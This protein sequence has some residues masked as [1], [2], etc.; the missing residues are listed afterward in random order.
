MGSR[1]GGQRPGA[2]EVTIHSATRILYFATDPVLWNW[3]SLNCEQLRW[4]FSGEWGDSGHML[5]A[6][7]SPQWPI[8]INRTSTTCPPPPPLP[9]SAIEMHLQVQW[10]T[11]NCHTH[12]INHPFHPLLNLLHSCKSWRRFKHRRYEHSF[13]LI[14]NDWVKVEETLHCG[15]WW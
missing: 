13:M 9:Q 6:N 15:D 7:H 11:V 3:H 2:E 1:L 4:P 5:D 8:S 10:K 12:C 14:W